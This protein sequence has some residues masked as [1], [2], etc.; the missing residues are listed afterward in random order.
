MKVR[1]LFA[2]LITLALVLGSLFCLTGCSKTEEFELTESNV[3]GLVVISKQN[4][5]IKRYLYDQY[6]LYDPDTH[7]MYSMID[8]DDGM[9]ITV[10]YNADGSLKV[11]NP[12]K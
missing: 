4:N 1:K 9:T 8:S 5:F 10:L 11:Y 3:D 12:E 7:V 6:I 2:I